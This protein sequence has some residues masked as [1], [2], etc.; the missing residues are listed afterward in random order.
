MVRDDRFGLIQG[1][2]LGTPLFFLADV[3]WGWRIRLA[4]GV[5]GWTFRGLYYGFCCL[6]AFLCIKRPRLA[7]LVGVGESSV[8]AL[9]LVLRVMLPVI[10]A[11]GRL[12][13]GE[14]V[15]GLFT[16]SS[17]VNFC[18]TGGMLVVSFHRNVM[19]LERM[20]Q[21]PEDRTR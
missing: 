13:A 17:F 21:G 19:A 2:Y 12:L 18:L 7:P 20:G 3:F 11:P 9:L 5:G 10:E 6:C 14:P 15:V 4:D 16:L 8:N 1:Y